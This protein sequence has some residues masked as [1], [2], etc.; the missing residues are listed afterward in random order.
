MMD[1]FSIKAL[2]S[3]MTL[4]SAFAL[5]GCDQAPQEDHTNIQSEQATEQNM[6]DEI[7]QSSSAQDTQNLSKG[8]MLNIARDIAK[9][10][11]ETDDYIALLKQSQNSLEQAIQNKNVQQL[12]ATSGDLNQELHGLHDTLLSLN[13]KSNEIDQIRQNLLVAN[14]QLLNMP[15]LHGQFDLAKINF[16][17]IEKQLNTIQMDMVKLASLVLK[18]TN[19]TQ[20]SAA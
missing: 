8:N 12:K 13:L 15:L 19:N 14:Q 9:L 7:I 4:L 17:Q 2:L 3:S 20:N 10:Q 1:K 16:E 18:S 11:L 6:S 5:T